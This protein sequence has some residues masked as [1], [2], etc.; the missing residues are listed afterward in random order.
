MEKCDGNV[1]QFETK[2]RD[3]RDLLIRPI[4]PSDKNDLQNVMHHLSRLS[5]YH[6]FFAAKNE[7]T[8]SELK[9]FTEIDFKKQVGL[10]AILNDEKI[11]TT[12]G[13]GCYVVS[14]PEGTVPRAEFALAVEEE[15]KNLGVGTA[16]LRQ[17][18]EIARANKILSLSAFVMEENF[19]MLR[20][21]DD[22]SFPKT[23]RKDHGIIEF[24][25]DIGG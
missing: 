3:G 25:I 5:R 19:E 8:E 13:T 6:R 24:V 10:L 20:L 12:V 9:Y 14:N 15:Y 23:I 11:C 2:T 21:I 22:L 18:V 4:K 1:L 7:L 17:L 16:L